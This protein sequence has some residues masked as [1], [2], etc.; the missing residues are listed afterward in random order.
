[1]EKVKAGFII[2]ILIAAFI[3]VPNL[4]GDMFTS[5]KS[6]A[7]GMKQSADSMRDGMKENPI[8]IVPDK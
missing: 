1:M 8:K 4:A 3:V 7:D 5:C 2:I 6:I